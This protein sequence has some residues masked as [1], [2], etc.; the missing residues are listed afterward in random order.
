MEETEIIVEHP[1]SSQSRLHS[2]FTRES[3]HSSSLSDEEQQEDDTANGR[4]WETVDDDDLLA[5][6]RMPAWSGRGSSSSSSRRS[7]DDRHLPEVP[8]L[9]LSTSTTTSSLPTLSPTREGGYT[10][11]A[12]VTA[13]RRNLSSDSG[14]YGDVI[15]ER[16][17]DGPLTPIDGEEE[18]LK[19]RLPSPAGQ[20]VM[21]SPTHGHSGSK[22]LRFD[23]FGPDVVPAHHHV[24]HK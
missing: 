6:R 13:G 15:H 24:S 11:I 10:A 2:P 12:A 18:L 19:S 1:L 5:T 8:S 4:G 16:D 22:R 23:S 7:A 14:R 21:L 9:T 20:V 17:E 3:R